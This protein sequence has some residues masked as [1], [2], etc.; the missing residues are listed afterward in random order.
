M[1]LHTDIP[2]RAEIDRLIGAS[3]AHCVSIYLPTHR[4]TQET[5]KD[6]L[7]LRDLTHQA[8]ER[9]R[10]A[11]A[12]THEIADIEG[13]DEDSAGALIMAARAHWFE[14]AEQE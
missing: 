9:L 6:R 3:P 4:V 1:A 12:D 14:D 5:A 11:G 13:L 8:V 10:A 7:V 2:T